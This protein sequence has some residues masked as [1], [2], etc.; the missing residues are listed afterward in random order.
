MFTDIVGSTALRDAIVAKHGENEGN[1]LYGERVQGPH[2]ERVRAFIE[3]HQGFEV[4]TN[5]DSFM[6]A[7]AQPE[8]AIRCAVAIQRSLRDE[9]IATAD[10]RKSLAVRIGMH[11]GAATFVER[12]GKPDYDGH[13]VNIAARVESLLKEGERVYC[14][15]ATAALVKIGPDIRFHN[16]G[17]YLLKGLSEKVEIFDALWNDAM[18]P[19]PPEQPQEKLPYPW[20]TQWIGREREMVELRSALESSRLITLHGMGGVGKTRLAVETL[21]A[22]GGGLPREIVFVRLENTPDTPGGLLA[23]I[24]DALALTEADAP[25]LNALRRQ[26]Q[27]GDR[28][29]LLDNFESVI[30]AARDVPSLA[31]T[32]GMKVLVT[33]Q[34]ALGVNGERVIELEPM[35]IKGD[36][37]R[38]ESYRLFVGLAQQRDAGWQP[39]D[40][41]AMRDVLVATDGLPYLIELV[42]AVA[43]K[44]MLRQLADELKT[45]L[46]A[47]IARPGFA[48]AERH[49][50]VQACLEWALGR[51]PENERNALPRLAIFSDSFEAEAA[52]AITATPQAS[53]DVLVDASLLR[54]DRRIGRYSMLA[55]TRQFA[56][57]LIEAE[58]QKRLGAE[59]AR[60][61]IEHL[62]K[63]DD[64]LRA[65]GGEAQ[66]G[67]RRWIKANFENVEQA[68]AFA[69]AEDAELF[70]RAV[71]AFNP[72]LDQTCAFSELVRLNEELVRQLG[73]RT[74]QNQ[75][76]W[77][78]A[79]NSLGNAY[80]SL[81]T[82]RGRNL[83][84]AIARYEAA[85]EI[86]SEQNSPTTW[87]MTQNNL[88]LAYQNLPVGDR[89]DNLEKAIACC[90][91]A[92]GVWT[93]RDFPVQWATVQNNLGIAYDALPTGDRNQNL[94]HA[95]ACYEAALRI[96]TQHDF[97]T[98][99]A[100][101]QN[102]LGAA[103]Q[104]LPVGDRGENLAK[105]TAYYEA[106]LR[107][108]TEHDFPANW[109]TTQNNLGIV[110]AN[111]STGN[112]RENLA[113]S[114][115]YYEA[116]LRGWTESDFPEDWA[117]T[118]YN[119]GNV[120]EELGVGEPEHNHQAK[121]CFES[122][123]RGFHSVGLAE[124][125]EEAR[126]R[127]GKLTKVLE[128]PLRRTRKTPSRRK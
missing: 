64:A 86:L 58:E 52:D 69:A 87:A 77:A 124:A 51:L 40:D 30:A 12:D 16:C 21:L 118:Q 24:R 23:A 72:Y 46:T 109:A 120:H 115:A 6:V 39:D 119:L 81:Q 62:D 103:Y 15:G 26:L 33:S 2:N 80:L 49:A 126:Q 55:T 66:A 14:S 104:V 106:A 84:K 42:A 19:A 20:L 13:A 78:N 125:A 83:A 17:P 100:M 82:E 74:L 107:V 127:A 114:I 53:L 128:S 36:L 4:K 11:T 44:R 108:W 94:R 76:L 95:I 98:D 47:V 8:D 56:K 90:E 61:F 28:L 1:R 67:A 91:K 97:P 89:G 105:A 29:L 59:H 34:Q 50:S 9:P 37:M 45:H 99:W 113:E 68:I 73:P 116:A 25:D 121:T 85:L 112:R 41:A 31:A 32:S 92:L 7:F 88:G 65:K 18:Q 10:P 111:L 63:A 5:G 102:N 38:L 93:E 54:F 27:G 123:A 43:S 110:Y 35:A 75:G 22:Q 79:Q 71:N 101:I 57:E 3:K 117:K 60:W 70:V 48:S 122:A 96:S